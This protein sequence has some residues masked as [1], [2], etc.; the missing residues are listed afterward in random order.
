MTSAGGKLEMRVNQSTRETIVDT[1]EKL[2]DA[3]VG[4]LALADELKNISR[5]CQV[6][7]ISRTHFYDI[8]DAFERYGRDGLAPGSGSGPGRRT[9]RRRSW[10][11]FNRTLNEE[12]NTRRAHHGYRTQG[13][14]PMQTFS[15]HHQAMEAPQ[16]A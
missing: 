15:E 8:K 2:I 11:R 12:F 14:T 13:R 16:A 1:R 7:G 5:A 6:A 3:L 9:R 10:A 4:M